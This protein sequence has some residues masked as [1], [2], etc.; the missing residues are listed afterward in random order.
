M[1][2]APVGYRK[3]SAKSAAGKLA[4]HGGKIESEIAPAAR[5]AAARGKSADRIEA[6]T[7]VDRSRRDTAVFDKRSDVADDMPRRRTKVE[8][9][10]DAGIKLDAI[11]D[12]RE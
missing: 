3:R 5:A 6:E 9:D 7:H 11:E 1:D 8:V 2:D 10:C 12:A 4:D